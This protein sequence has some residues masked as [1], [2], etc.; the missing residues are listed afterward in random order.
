MEDNWRKMTE[1][2][3]SKSSSSAM[4][5][6]KNRVLNR[7]LLEELLATRE[8]AYLASHPQTGEL[9]IRIVRAYCRGQSVVRIGMETHCSESTVYRAIDRVRAFL[10]GEWQ[11][12][13]ADTFFRKLRDRVYAESPDFGDEDASSVLELLYSA[14]AELNNFDS[15]EAKE[16]FHNI[17]EQLNHKPLREIDEIMDSVCTL[18]REYEK[19]G[20]TEG[21]KLGI[22]LRDELCSTTI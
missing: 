2:R 3:Q 19:A 1:R 9:D 6:K 17:Y 21:V 5:M 22:R 10:A 11:T 12:A 16:L 14:F 8:E 4:L 15:H 20:F 7:K 18:C 13:P